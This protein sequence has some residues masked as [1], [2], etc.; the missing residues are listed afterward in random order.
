[1]SESVGFIFY[2]ELIGC[3]GNLAE[4]FGLRVSSF[5]GKASIS[6]SKIIGKGE[7]ACV[8]AREGKLPIVSRE[9]LKK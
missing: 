1:V 2:F 4:K 9:H 5:R 3:L 6:S 7:R 8:F